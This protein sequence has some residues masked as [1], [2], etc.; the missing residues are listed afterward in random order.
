[1]TFFEDI[2]YGFLNEDLSCALRHR[3]VDWATQLIGAGADTN[4]PDPENHDR[5]PLH[6]AV[7]ANLDPSMIVTLLRAGADVKARDAYGRTPLHYAVHNSTTV[8]TLLLAGADIEAVDEWGHTPLHEASRHATSLEPVHA[9]LQAGA[10]VEACTHRQ[11][12]PLHAAVFN[13]T[14]GAGIVNALVRAGAF[15]NATDMYR[16]TPLHEATQ[17]VLG[18]DIVA[19][20]VRVGANVNAQD[21]DGCTPLHYAAR[22]AH[23]SMALLHGCDNATVDGCVLDRTGKLWVHYTV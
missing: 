17:L 16:R 2:G 8:V 13:S 12:T 9:L 4:A 22:H 20:L 19:V 11:Q 10:K 15:P 3:L 7:H 14:C 23:V 5:T 6:V 21:G 1:M 18:A